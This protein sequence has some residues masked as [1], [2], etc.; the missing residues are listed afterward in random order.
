MS[1]V[2]SRF[3][4]Q[5]SGKLQQKKNSWSPHQLVSELRSIPSTDSRRTVEIKHL[6]G[7]RLVVPI[8][9]IVLLRSLKCCKI[10][11]ENITIVIQVSLFLLFMKTVFFYYRYTNYIFRT[12]IML[13]VNVTS[14]AEF[15]TWMFLISLIGCF[16]IL[17]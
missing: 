12:L 17:R 5:N 4:V 6:C 16:N 13:L 9:I 15:F 7:S 1:F 2:S 3:L 11:Q 14:L 10:N 8:I